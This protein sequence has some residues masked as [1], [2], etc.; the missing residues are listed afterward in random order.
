MKNNFFK[1][2]LNLV[3]SPRDMMIKEWLIFAFSYFLAILTVCCLTLI[4]EVK[5][6]YILF[7]TVIPY[8]YY[9]IINIIDIVLLAKRKITN[10]LT[11]GIFRGY[12]ED[13]YILKNPSNMNFLKYNICC[14]ILFLIS[15][16]PV[17]VILNNMNS[18]LF[19]V[20]MLSSLILLKCSL[21]AI[22]NLFEMEFYQSTDDK[23]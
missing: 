11:F 12:E 7:Y 6:N 4:F 19:I 3:Y 9:G 13:Y 23:L 17:V 16:T 14:R 1:G 15:I 21:L 5:Q 8:T 2:S 20:N 10:K 18:A 22:D